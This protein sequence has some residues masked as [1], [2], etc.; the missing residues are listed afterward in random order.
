[1]QFFHKIASSDQTNP[2][3]GD[4]LK[5]GNAGLTGMS[6]IGFSG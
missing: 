3:F 1:L 2:I 4:S 5:D 6:K